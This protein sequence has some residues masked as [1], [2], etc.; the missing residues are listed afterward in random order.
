M[1]VDPQ[2]DL[3]TEIGRLFAVSRHAECQI[4]DHVLVL[5]EYLVEG[6]RITGAMT[7]DQ[8]EIRFRG[9][10]GHASFG[11]NL[12]EWTAGD[13]FSV[14]PSIVFDPFDPA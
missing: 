13:L 5:V 8:L 2:K 11:C 3:L 12:H 9:S 4:E 10:R 1:P 6:S 7:L 14:A